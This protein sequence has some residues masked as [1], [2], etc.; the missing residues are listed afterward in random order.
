MFALL[1]ALFVPYCSLAITLSEV[2]GPFPHGRH[3]QEKN[4]T[5]SEEMKTK[6][7]ND[8]LIRYTTGYLRMDLYD[9]VRSVWI[10]A[11][12]LPIGVCFKEGYYGG[13]AMLAEVI[14][15]DN[16]VYRSTNSYQSGDCTGEFIAFPY[17]QPVT[18]GDRQLEQKI[19]HIA[20][21]DEAV[22]L[23]PKNSDGLIVT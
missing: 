12:I 16:V 2:R 14:V 23:I 3:L 9:W 5:W 21:F 1:I 22:Q 13:S 11:Q 20:T 17:S 18:D 10:Q 6:F 15:A 7:Q 19:S 8:T 4:E